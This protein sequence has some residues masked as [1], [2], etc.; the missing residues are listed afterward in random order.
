MAE[1]QRC[2]DCGLYNNLKRVPACCDY[3]SSGRLCHDKFICE[4]T[5][6]WKCIDCDHKTRVINH[7]GWTPSV[8]CERCGQFC[9]CPEWYGPTPPEYAITLGLDP[10]TFTATYDMPPMIFNEIHLRGCPEIQ[11]W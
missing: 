8:Y 7:N 4:E 9:G 3:T 5:C 11:H 6:G 1:R 10:I 2:D